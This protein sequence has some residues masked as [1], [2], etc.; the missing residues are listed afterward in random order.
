VADAAPR[1]APRPWLLVMLGVAVLA[2]IAWY[3]WPAAEPAAAPSNYPRDGVATQGRGGFTT[4]PDVRLEAL[5]QPPPQVREADRNPFRFQPK[6]PPPPPAP[7]PSAAHPTEPE[8]V[9]PEPPAPPPPPPP[10]P[11]IQLK[12]FGVIDAPN[13]RRLAALTDGKAVFHGEEGQIIDGRYR[14]VKIGVESIIVEYADGRG[15]T[16]IPLRGQ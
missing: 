9:G 10:P 11:P 12:F 5:K 1:Q 13:G 15:R 3:M 16:T 7:P 6:P 4:P 14:I 2:L 8:K